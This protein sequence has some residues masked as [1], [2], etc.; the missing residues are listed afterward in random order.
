MRM[1]RN[2][3]FNILIFTI[4][5]FVIL[6]LVTPIK[7][8]KVNAESK[9]TIVL[10]GNEKLPPIIYDDKGIARGVVVDIAKAIGERIDYNVEIKTINW[11]DAQQTLLN[12]EAHGL[13]HINQSP[14]R[15]GIFDFSLPLLK[16]EFSIFVH[17]D[18]VRIW[19]LN[20][21][22]GKR[23]G[24][25][26]GGYPEQ[27]LS[28]YEDINIKYINHW[29]ISFQDLKSGDLDAII[30]DR[31]IG[32][33][34]LANYKIN[35]IKVVEPPIEIKYSSIAVKK[36]DGETLSLIN[37]G[38]KEISEDGTIDRIMQ[39]WQRKRVR[40]VTEDYLHS[41]YLRSAVVGLLV[42]SLISLYLV[43]KYRNLSKKLEMSVNERT[44]ELYETNEKLK[45]ANLE[46]RRLTLLDGLTNIENRR[47][48]DI[49]FNKA[50]HNSIKDKKHLSLL[51]L[52]IDDYKV[53]ND[54]YGHL[55]GDE[56]L[57]NIAS[58]LKS[59]VSRPRDLVAR[60]GGEEF[61]II[62]MDTTVDEALIIGEKIRWEIEKLEVV[63]EIKG[64]ITVSIGVASIV[65][66]EEM[67][68][69]ELID[70]ADKALY[71][72]KESGK[73]Q[74]IVHKWENYVEI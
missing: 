12:G 21:L 57:K 40:Y 65:P 13:L 43:A 44:K 45:A 15:E 35:D 74:V 61:A 31:W 23:V 28:D 53:I 1:I 10:L 3:M 2:F 50:W 27:L 64:G 46:L 9:G 7:G 11:E 42:I 54:T 73:N 55:I 25:E 34:E 17:I 18:N 5:V 51:M 16:S 6:I 39:Q 59:V 60:Y 63:N 33:Y 67:E 29:N 69:S 22:K 32:E 47:A 8:L 58:I 41:L 68:P 52:D 19:N 38:L 66:I 36:G 37:E 14:Q 48:F 24:V 71:L 30:V 20:D 70:A 4:S 62:L 72:A 56:V 26:A 49:I